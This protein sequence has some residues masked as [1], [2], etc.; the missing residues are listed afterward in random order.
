[1][2]IR[3]EELQKVCSKILFAVD[4][5]NNSIITE[6]LE[7]YTENNYLYMSIT[8]REYF[9]KVRLDIQEEIEFNATVPADVFLKLIS[10]MT[11]ET[12]EFS[13]NDNCLVVKGNGTYKLPMIYEG[14]TLLKLP[15]ITI[16]NI[17]SQFDVSRHI[18]NSI[19]NYNSKE[20]SKKHVVSNPVQN[21][22]Y[23]DEK[24]CITFTTG[25]CVNKFILPTTIKILLT[26][27]IV[28]LFKL[29]NYDI[30]HVDY[31]KD[32]L[33]NNLMQTKIKFYTDDI[34]LTAIINS[35]DNMINSV[36]ESAIRNRAF[37]T[38]NYSIVINKKILLNAI[39]RIMLFVNST[40]GFYGKFN[41][42]ENQLTLSN[43]AGD[44]SE[45]I[46][47]ENSVDNLSDYTAIFDIADLKLIISEIKSDF[48]TMSFGDGQAAVIIDKDIYNIIPECIV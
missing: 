28:K 19:I 33:P 18:L 42:T 43:D 27:K 20:L 44:N 11:T 31:G 45:V 25:A 32:T 14:D 48:I 6:T 2:I 24:G 3:C 22:Y 10:K 39:D 38:Y 26:D 30:I 34:V 1:M 41:F 40:M 16:N 17:T 12:I 29:F 4:T 7:M 47:Y 35:D 15:E 9:V 46:A 36:P 37:D 23:I 13:V 5:S 21:M 8:N